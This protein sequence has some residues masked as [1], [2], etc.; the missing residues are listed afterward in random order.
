MYNKKVHFVYNH[1]PLRLRIYYILR[2]HSFV[3]NLLGNQ[4]RRKKNIFFTNW[5]LIM[6]DKTQE[7]FLQFHFR[8]L[9]TKDNSS[10][11]M[12]WDVSLYIKK[13]NTHSD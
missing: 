11:S 9:Y 1:L 5:L 12:T 2:T 7:I 13:E 10:I 8:T 3:K 4:Q 6:V